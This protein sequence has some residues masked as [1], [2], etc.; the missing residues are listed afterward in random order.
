[1]TI[2]DG[3]FEPDTKDAILST[4]L[5]HATEVWGVDEFGSESRMYKFYEP[6]AE[7]LA[8]LQV[9]ARAILNSAQLEYAEGAALDLLVDLIGVP[10]KPARKATTTLTFSRATPA[11]V[12]YT[13]PKGTRVQTDSIDAVRFKTTESATLTAGTTDVANVAAEAEVGGRIGNVGLNRLTEM[14]NPPIGIESVTNTVEAT[15]GVDAENDDQLR[16]RA[17]NELAAGSSATALGLRNALLQVSGVEDVT[18]F[19]NTTPSADGDGRPSHSVECVV[20]GGADGDIGQKL[21]ESKAAGGGLTSGHVGTSVTTS[22]VLDNGQSLPVEFSRPTQQVAYFDMTLATSDTYEGDDAVR[23][24]LVNYLGGTL[25]SG[26]F[27]P[28]QLGIGDD[29]LYTKMVAAIMSVEGVD[30]IT[31]LAYDFS[32][33]PVTT[34]GDLAVANSEVAS[35]VADDTHIIIT[36]T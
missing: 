4:L 17:R 22:G 36:T 28:G 2:V 3:R 32:A 34:S 23:E 35:T 1:M 10:R 33:S 24:A 7:L 15:G 11:A 12:D 16:Q 30:D 6:V 29:V 25:T 26:D 9:D 21:V 5:T 18:L 27:T 8:E 13:I 20:L 19:I 14:L 31:S